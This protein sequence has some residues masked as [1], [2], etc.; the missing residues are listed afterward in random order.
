MAWQ[1]TQVIDPAT[2][3]PPTAVEEQGSAFNLVGEAQAVHATRS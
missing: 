1:K 3:L 2:P